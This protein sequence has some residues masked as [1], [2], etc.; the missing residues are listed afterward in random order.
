MP[1]HGGQAEPTRRPPPPAAGAQTG[2]VGAAFRAHPAAPQWAFKQPVADTADNA[3]LSDL[4]IFPINGD[5]WHD[6]RVSCNWC[7]NRYVETGT[8]RASRALKKGFSFKPDPSRPR[9]CICFIPLLNAADSRAG[10]TR[11][12]WLFAQA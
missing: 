11:W 10:R 1:T 3:Q 9:R 12:P 8:C 6:D 2:A 7:A 5:A 4:A